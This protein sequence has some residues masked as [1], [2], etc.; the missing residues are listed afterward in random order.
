MTD[1][2]VD[3]VCQLLGSWDPDAV[4]INRDTGSYADYRNV[5]PIYFE[6][7]LVK[8]RG[9][10][11][12]VRSPRGRPVFEQTGGSPPG[13]AFE[14]KR[15][16]PII[17]MAN[18]IAGMSHYRDDVRR[19]ATPYEEN[20]DDVT[21]LFLVYPIIV[22]TDAEACARRERVVSSLASIERVLTSVSTVTD[23][24]FSLFE[25][26]G[27]LPRVTINGEHGSL[28]KFA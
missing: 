9:P 7:R 1:G 17:P 2:Y 20:S 12:T 18:G 8:V 14:A 5:R 16:H 24:D 10:L 26:D 6:R 13:S 25:P 27:P 15:E 4:V 19:H 3:L 11:D 21:A 23:I 22:E 28:D